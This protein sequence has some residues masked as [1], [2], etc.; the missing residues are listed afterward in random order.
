MQISHATTARLHAAQLNEWHSRRA[1]QLVQFPFP[2]FLGF[3]TGEP[4]LVAGVSGL[5]PDDNGNCR[6]ATD[7]YDAAV[8]E[9]L[10]LES[11][12]AVCVWCARERESDE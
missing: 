9:S 12:V 5:L 7:T 10:L 3:S 8:T 11:Y 2:Q 6:A 4:G 1:A